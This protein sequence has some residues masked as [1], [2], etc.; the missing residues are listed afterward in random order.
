MTLS[1]KSYSADE[2]EG[3]ADALDTITADARTADDQALAAATAHAAGWLHDRARRGF[4]PS[5][6]QASKP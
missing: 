2:L 6:A 5:G 4:I 1:D 3:V